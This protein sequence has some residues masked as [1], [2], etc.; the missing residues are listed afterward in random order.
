M[1]IGVGR[2]FLIPNECEEEEWQPY[3]QLLQPYTAA[4]T[5]VVLEQYRC[6]K[7]F[8][9]EAYDAAYLHIQNMNVA[10]WYVTVYHDM[11]DGPGRTQ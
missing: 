4:G 10:R 9:V 7:Q 11:V 3:M 2:F 1:L 8:Q 6:S 5:V